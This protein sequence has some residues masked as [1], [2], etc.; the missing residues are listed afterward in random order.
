MLA[1][2]KKWINQGIAV[3][4]CYYR[5][6]SPR[7][8]KWQLYQKQLPTDIELKKWFQ[9]RYVNMA[10][11]TGWQNLTV[12]DFD[13]MRQYF[14]WCAWAKETGGKAWLVASLSLRALTA[15][16]V[17]IYTITANATRNAKFKG[18]DIRAN[19]GYVVAPPSVHPSGLAYRWINPDAPI[20]SVTGI[21]AVLPPDWLKSHAEPKK[22]LN[23]EPPQSKWAVVNTVSNAPLSIKGV[24]ERV[25]LL[26]LLPDA[27][28]SSADGRWYKT[29]CP[30]HNDRHPSFWID[31][32]RGICGCHSCGGRP[33]DVINLYAA[34]HNLDNTTAL[35]M[36][37]IQ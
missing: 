32:K 7:L 14:R 17:H 36:L 24:R 18:G 26:D 10:V 16:G 27:E 11:V 25:S 35:R 30:F 19:G 8:A 31:V 37:A 33:M 12:I 3:I 22:A 20:L 28:R 1:T 6:K 29:V 9:R 5:Q 34:L 15:S 13:D 2:A 21:K 4:P 23:T